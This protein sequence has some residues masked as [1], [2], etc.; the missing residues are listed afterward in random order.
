MRNPPRILHRDNDLVAVHKPAGLLVHRSPVDRHAHE[1]LLQQLRDS[2]GQRL[3]PVHRLD[4]PTSGLIILACHP[5]AARILAAQFEQ[6]Q[7]RKTYVALVRGWVGSQTIDYPLQTLDAASAE[8][9]GAAQ[10]AQ[11][12]V[13]QLAR[14]ELPIANS[15]HPTTRVSLAALRPHTGRRHQLRRHLK[16]ISHPILGDTAYGDLRQ[17]RAFAA[18]GGVNRLWLHAL[19]LTFRHPDGR[20]CRYRAPL[21]DHWRE[22]LHNMAAQSVMQTEAYSCPSPK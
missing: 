3:Y 19:S 17:N 1:F 16:H 7:V 21:E 2:L 22:I 5:Q 9:S 12:R 20:I 18:W 13:R 15:R 4:R 6:R 14:Y 11:S 8:K 10:E